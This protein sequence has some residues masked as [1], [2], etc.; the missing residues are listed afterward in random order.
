MEDSDKK[1]S[2]LE[3]GKLGGEILETMMNGA[4]I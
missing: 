3:M 1:K 4:P 2:A